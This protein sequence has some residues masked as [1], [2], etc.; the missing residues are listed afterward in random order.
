MNAVNISKP[1]ASYFA[2]KTKRKHNENEKKAEIKLAILFAEH[3]VATLTVDHLVPLSKTIFI[4]SKICSDITLGRTKCGQIINNVVGTHETN[5][6]VEHLK[7]N[8]FSILN[9][10]S[11]VSQKKEHVF[12]VR[13]YTAI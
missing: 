9:D 1:I 8:F 10:E 13:Y 3:N 12:M 7:S 6:L 11:T 4:D 5:I 2:D